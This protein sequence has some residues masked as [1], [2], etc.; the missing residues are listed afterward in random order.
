M[1]HGALIGAE[2]AMNKKHGVGECRKVSVGTG[3]SEEEGNRVGG[4][5]AVS[6]SVK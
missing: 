1:A 4:G 2:Y 5:G 3:M 6:T